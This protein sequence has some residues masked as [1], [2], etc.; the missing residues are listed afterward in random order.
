M[1]NRHSPILAR[2]YPRTPPE[3]DLNRRSFEMALKNGDMESIRRLVED[4]HVKPTKQDFITVIDRPEII[5]SLLK[6]GARPDKDVL[7]SAIRC[8]YIQTAIHLVDYGVELEIEALNEAARGHDTEIYDYLVDHGLK[9]DDTTLHSAAS[10]GN[11]EL[12]K[13]LIDQGIQ[14]TS[15]DVDLSTGH[16]ET[17]K[18]LIELGV[19]PTEWAMEHATE[20]E[21]IEL[22]VVKMLVELGMELPK[23]EHIILT[24]TYE[25]DLEAIKYFIESWAPDYQPSMDLIY[26]A[27][28]DASLSGEVDIVKYFVE[29]GAELSNAT[30]QN[31]VEADSIEGVKYCVENG[32]EVN[33]D[34]VVHAKYYRMDEIAEYL[35]S[36][37][38]PPSPPNETK[39]YV[40]PLGS[41]SHD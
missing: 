16:L 40:L 2:D 5:E 20:G 8:G 21:Y 9:P 36:V 17:F 31:F 6:A 24:A 1:D 3:E 33:E 34:D 27:M 25:G 14:P 15:H 12:V 41:E 13:R 23:D 30:L 26:D 35:K 29:L 39:Y 38:R 18:Y 19:M 32:I 10:S 28:N 4:H 7:I 22:D 37:A 11:L